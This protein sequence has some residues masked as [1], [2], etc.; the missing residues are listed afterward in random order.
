VSATLKERK[1][2]PRYTF[3][4]VEWV[5]ENNVVVG[6]TTGAAVYTT[7]TTHFTSFAVFFGT[8]SRS[9][10]GGSCNNGIWIACV[11]LAASVAAFSGLV[12]VLHIFSLRFHS[13]VS[14]YEVMSEES[15][16]EHIKKLTSGIFYSN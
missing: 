8:S 2:S 15:F 3:P 4:I 10:S 1:E 9:S 11:A 12:I 6:T 5:I 14:G 13:F 16:N 7:E